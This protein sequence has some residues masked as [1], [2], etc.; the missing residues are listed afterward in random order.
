M[1][2]SGSRLY[3][4]P[5]YKYTQNHVMIYCI[6]FITLISS[7]VAVAKEGAELQADDGSQEYCKSS[8]C[9]DSA[10]HDPAVGNEGGQSV[11]EVEVT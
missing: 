1:C 2:A 5:T 8:H 9:Q 7:R 11:G 4:A 3:K 6:T 10:S